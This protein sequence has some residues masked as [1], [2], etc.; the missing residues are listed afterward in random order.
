VVLPSD[1]FPQKKRIYDRLF[2]VQNGEN[3]LG[4]AIWYWE[5]ILG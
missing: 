3:S 4:E 2:W 5:F 1:F